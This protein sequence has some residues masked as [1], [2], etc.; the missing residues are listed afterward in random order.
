MGKRGKKGKEN[1]LK[2]AVRVPPFLLQTAGKGG[3]PALPQKRRCKKEK[4]K[5]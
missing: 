3:K 5:H 2:R 1:T 4:E